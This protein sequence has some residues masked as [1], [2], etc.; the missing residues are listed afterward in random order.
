MITL[1]GAP[2]GISSFPDGTILMKE[3]LRTSTQDIRW[4]YENDREFLALIYLVKHLRV[5]GAKNIYLDMPYIPNARQDRVKTHNDI[6]TLKYFAELLNSLNL[7]RVSV[8][9]PHSNVSE[10]LIDNLVVRTPENYISMAIDKIPEYHCNNPIDPFANPV[11]SLLIFYPDEGAMKRYSGMIPR[12][13]AYG[14]KKRDWE[15]GKIIGLD[16]VDNG[17]CILGKDILIIDDICSKGGTF[18]HSAK[19]LKELGAN[20]IYLYV[21]HCENT[22]LE[23]ELLTSGLIKKVFTTDS[24]FTKEHEMIEVLK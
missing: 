18:L 1:N 20:D 6:F 9:D 22:I 2:V 11:S 4:C 14:L 13:H 10:A 12:P 5:H 8:L 15:T 24:I 3:S 21:S 16:V 7:T 19:K 17:N 23:G